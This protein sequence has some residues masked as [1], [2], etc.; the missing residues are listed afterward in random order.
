MNKTTSS[1]NKDYEDNQRNLVVLTDNS[2]ANH[3]TLL[4]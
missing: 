4:I 3:E 1:T 2:K